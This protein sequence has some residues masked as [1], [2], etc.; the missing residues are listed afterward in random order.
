MNASL[1]IDKIV[2]YMG[3][4]CFLRRDKDDLY[5]D[6]AFCPRF[7]EYRSTGQIHR[8]NSGEEILVHGRGIKRITI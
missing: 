5:I 2:V 6:E 3:R 8:L 4:S 7:G 1:P